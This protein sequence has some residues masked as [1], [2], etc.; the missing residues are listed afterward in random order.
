MASAQYV[1]QPQYAPPDGFEG[2]VP[3]AQQAPQREIPFNRTWHLVKIVL[4]GFNIAFGVI[5]IGISVALVMYSFSSSFYLIFSG[6][7]A[8]AAICWDTTELITICARG[9]RRGIHPGA[10]VGL[11]LLFWLVFMVSTGWEAAN[12]YFRDDPRS[13]VYSS[14]Q[15]T[16]MQDAVLAFTALLF[17]SNFTLFVRACVECKQRNVRPPPV[18]MVPVVG[19]PPMQPAGSYQPYPYSPQQASFQPQYDKGQMAGA[20]IDTTEMAAQPGPDGTYY[21]PGSR[22]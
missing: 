20:N 3:Y 6:F 4:R 7:P 15:I 22:T 1:P 11:H 21:G 19:P 5:I 10:H 12:V 18:Y 14:G 2:Y 17:L 8:A 9:G 16:S 13:W